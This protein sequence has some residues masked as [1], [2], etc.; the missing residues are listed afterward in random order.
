M[1]VAIRNY[2]SVRVINTGTAKVDMH[3]SG[4]SYA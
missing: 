4:T 1:Q 3:H 2:A